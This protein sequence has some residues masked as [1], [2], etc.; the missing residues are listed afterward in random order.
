MGQEVLDKRFS[1]VGWRVGTVYEIVPDLAVYAQYSEAAD[2]VSGLLML[3]PANQDFDLSTGRQIEIG[4][5]QAFWDG[6]GEWTLAR[7]EEHT[8]ELQS[9]M[10][11]SYAVFCVKKKT[12]LHSRHNAKR[13][14]RNH[15][16]EQPRTS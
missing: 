8:S 5:K 11:I 4:A 14:R 15:I 2:P 9:L 6:K 7:S 3:S 1:N 13:T 12:S 16:N 10:R